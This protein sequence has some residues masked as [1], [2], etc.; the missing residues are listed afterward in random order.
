MYSWIQCAL[1]GQ[2]ASPQ[3][4]I[5]AQP[6]NRPTKRDI[7]ELFG[8]APNDCSPV[9]IQTRAQRFCPFMRMTCTKRSNDQKEIYGVCTVSNGSVKKSA[10]TEVIVCPKRLYAEK[11][12]VLASV[13]KDVWGTASSDVFIGGTLGELRNRALKAVEPVVAFGQG[14]G[15]EISV[16]ANVDLSMDW[17]LQ[18]YTNAE[19]R[20]VAEDF[21]CIEVQSIDT[22]GNYHANRA[23]YMS[24]TSPG[25]RIVVPPSVHGLNWANVH[26]RL[27]PQL[28]RKGNITKL[29][30]RCRGFFFVVP[31]IVY[32]AFENVIG[33]IRVEQTH[34][35]DVLSVIT[36][37][38]GPFVPP[39]Q[40]RNLTKIRMLHYK[41]DTLAKAFI[42]HTDLNATKALEQKLRTLLC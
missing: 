22:T 18:R 24:L 16:S 17:V 31:D 7:A 33:K 5:L 1:R 10:G 2:V 25:Q 39:S 8:Y 40:I 11:F 26:K 3:P 34:G 20:L 6:T 4:P 42:T 41:H 37:S 13:A 23:A 9:A 14:S 36:Y 32:K 12:A 21:V 38:P 35:R 15:T 30:T 28:I 19:G 29:A 27:V